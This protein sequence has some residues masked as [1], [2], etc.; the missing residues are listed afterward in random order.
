MFD[1]YSNYPSYDNYTEDDELL[2]IKGSGKSECCGAGTYG[3]Y[4]ICESCGEHC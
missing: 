3:S 1:N 2:N 4:E